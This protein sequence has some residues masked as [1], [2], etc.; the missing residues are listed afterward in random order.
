MPTTSDTIQDAFFLQMD[1]WTKQAT[2]YFFAIDFESEKPIIYSLDELEAKGIKIQFPNTTTPSKETNTKAV[3]IT[4]KHPID[5]NAYKKQFDQVM[6]HLQRGDSFLLNLTC[7]TPIEIDGS[8]N[9]IFEQTEAK[10]KILFKDEFVCFSPETFVQIKEH[11]ISTFPMKGTIDASI[12]NAES[13]I[14]NDTKEIAE[15][16]TIV[17]LLRN[18]LSTVAD[19]VSVKRYRYIDHIKT[20]QKSLLQV[21]SEIEGKINACYHNKFGSLLRQLLPGGSISGAPKPKTLDI[22]RQTETHKRGYYTGICGVFDG[23]NLDSCV[24][25]RYIEQREGAHYYKSGGGITFQSKAENEYQE[26]IDKV[27]V[28]LD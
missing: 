27:Y 21:S 10:Y 24:I 26:V 9:Q 23:K 14:L 5:F 13:L 28:P 12:S 2:P 4:K 11:K 7:E 1:L 18:D 17:D 19:D 22:I 20:Q 15:H 25:I 3:Q 6:Y 16:A 8:I